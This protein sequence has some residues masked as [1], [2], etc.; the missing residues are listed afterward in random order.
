MRSYYILFIDDLRHALRQKRQWLA[1]MIFL[2]IFALAVYVFNEVQ[3]HLI[4]ETL[5]FEGGLFLAQR[6][7]EFVAGLIQGSPQEVTGQLSSIPVFSTQLFL[8]TL[9][10]V[11][12]LIIILHYNKMASE[13]SR[14]TTRFLLIR[15]SRASIYW[16]KFSSV[17]VEIIL[18]T[19]IITMIAL[20]YGHLRL[21]FF[22]WGDVLPISLKYWLASLP[23][24]VGFGSLVFMF[25]SVVKRPFMAL[26]WPLLFVLLGGIL[27]AWKPELSPFYIEYWKG[28]FL[29]EGPALRNAILIFLGLTTLFSTAGYLVFKQKDL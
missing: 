7:Y 18:I 17:V 11:P 20:L 13:I 4:R 26:L 14:K 16:A 5:Q 24:L 6:N 8:I 27:L 23:P 3:G 1:M 28:L 21:D 25:S 2:I 12:F 29:L 9:L 15:G 10:I 22:V 19:F